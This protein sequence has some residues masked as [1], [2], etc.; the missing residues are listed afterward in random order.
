VQA[1]LVGGLVHELLDIHLGLRQALFHVKV[2]DRVDVI[3][4]GL[5]VKELAHLGLDLRQD[6]LLAVITDLGERD[7]LD[8]GLFFHKDDDLQAI[9]LILAVNPHIREIPGI[10]K[11]L[12]VIGNDRLAV[13]LAHAVLILVRIVAMPMDL[14]P[15]TSIDL[16]SLPAG[17]SGTAGAYDSTAGG[18]SAG[19]DAASSAALTTA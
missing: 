9:G 2:L 5:L 17:A 4:E 14:L 6:D 12:E 10:V 13:F 11:A 7:L 15:W 19:L 3:V 8:N 18:G 1:H 16:T